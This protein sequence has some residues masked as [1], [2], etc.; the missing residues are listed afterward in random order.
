MAKTTNTILDPARVSDIAAKI[1]GACIGI[2]QPD[3]ERDEAQEALDEAREGTRSVREQIMVTVAALSAA[4]QWTRG[5]ITLACKS[6]VAMSN[7][8]GDKALATF[9]SEIKSVANPKVRDQ[10][11]A[12]LDL[13]DRAWNDERDAAKMADKKNPV[14]E[15]CKKLWSRAYHML[16]AMARAAEDD[17]KFVT[18]DDVV[19]Y[20]VANDPGLDAKKVANRL[21]AVVNTLQ[22]IFVDF[23]HDDIKSCVEYLELV[24]AEDLMAARQGLLNTTSVAG[25]LTPTVVSTTVVTSAPVVSTD[26]VEPSPGASD[27]LD[28]VL[29]EISLLAA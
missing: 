16:T 7:S 15:P 9:V 23:P 27:I 11:P 2:R 18:V 8:A 14:D 19:A 24:K 17:V 21:K 12:L 3:L 28:D 13:R 4:D 6:A 22:G 29:S 5:E 1:R 10:F 26:D 25:V 20:A